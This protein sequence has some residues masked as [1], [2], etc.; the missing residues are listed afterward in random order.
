MYYTFM[1]IVEFSFLTFD[2]NKIR[3]IQRVLHEMNESVRKTCCSVPRTKVLIVK[4][5]N[6]QE[7][8]HIDNIESYTNSSI[9]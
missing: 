9:S 2:V 1:V 8:Y 7:I 3:F 5:S 6:T 4:V